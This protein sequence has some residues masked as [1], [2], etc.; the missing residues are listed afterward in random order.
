MLLDQNKFIVRTKGKLFS[1]KV[2]FEI[3]DPE[4][5]NVLGK[6]NNVTG[7][8]A[9]LLGGTTIEVRDTADNSV[10]F[11]VKR[12]GLIFK[13]D[14][15]LD[16]GGQVIGR[17]KSK[18]FSFSGG[19]H[20]YD[21]DGKHLAEIQGKLLKA[22]YKFLTPDRKGE[23]GSVSRTW[24]G[25]AKSLLTGGDTYGVQMGSQFTNDEI[26][27]ILILGATIAVES[28]FKAKAGKKATE[29]DD[30]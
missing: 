26:A 2:S 19:Y 4:N 8:F 11:S 13:K 10:L 20:I 15:V 23:M 27:K 30:D 16:A 22:E 9:S 5:G 1:S 12:S 21:K 3:L 7:F 25:M 17:Y 24:G 28:I 14:Q 18:S 6:G 29:K